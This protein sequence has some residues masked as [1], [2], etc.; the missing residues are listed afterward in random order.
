MSA[1]VLLERAKAAGI[2]VLVR[3]G[4]MKVIGQ[5]DAIR[6]FLDELRGSKAEI[7][8][9]LESEKTA[10]NDPPAQ[11]DIGTRRP[12]GLSPTLLAASLA[13]DR[14][15]YE[16]GVLQSDPDRWA[17]PNGTAA[18]TRELALMANRL[19]RFTLLGLSV[20]EAERM[21]DKLQQRDREADDRHACVECASLSGRWRCGSF[22]QRGATAPGLPADYIVM[23]TRCNA[24]RAAV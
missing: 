15:I 22:R 11:P 9:L 7:L 4:G 12:P 16:S 1:A 21:A 3:D 19:A 20:N 8:A 23:L 17:W 24:W 2:T 5:P 10:A 14:Q 18:N 13:L 6:P